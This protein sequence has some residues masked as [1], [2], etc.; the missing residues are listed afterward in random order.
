MFK[1]WAFSLVLIALKS[2]HQNFWFG[3]DPPPPPPPL[4]KKLIFEQH[5]LGVRL[6]LVDLAVVVIVVLGV[7]VVVINKSAS[8]VVTLDLVFRSKLL[9]NPNAD[10]KT[11]AYFKPFSIASSD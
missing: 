2:V 4:W 7:I 8:V 10:I 9:L 6:P 3:R 5:F 11:T 1:F